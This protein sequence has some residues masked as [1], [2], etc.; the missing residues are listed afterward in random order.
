MVLESFVPLSALQLIE[1]RAQWDAMNDAWH[2]PGIEYAGNQVWGVLVCVCAHSLQ[3][4]CDQSI[5]SLAHT[6]QSFSDQSTLSLAH[7]HTQNTQNARDSLVYIRPHVHTCYARLSLVQRVCRR[8]LLLSI[9]DP[10]DA[11]RRPAG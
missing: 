11:P 5:L 8:S 7:T 10:A 2:I 1:E 4:F 3:S 9:C 6:L